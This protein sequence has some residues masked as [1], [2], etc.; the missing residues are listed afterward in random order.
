MYV[1]RV[2]FTITLANYLTEIVYCESY[3]IQSQVLHAYHMHEQLHD[4]YVLQ[5]LNLCP[6]I[7]ALLWE[8]LVG[9]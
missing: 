8:S 1:P 6:Y 5:S 7:V 2:F 9:L 3:D 4:I